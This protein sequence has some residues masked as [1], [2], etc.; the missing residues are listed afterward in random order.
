M[1]RRSHV[2]QAAASRVKGNVHV[3]LHKGKHAKVSS[4][5][6][7]GVC[8]RSG[9][10]AATL[11]PGSQNCREVVPD[12]STLYLCREGGDEGLVGLGRIMRFQ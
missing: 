8:D 10:G 6:R 3:A 7:Y 4:D 1:S 9:L 11:C 5:A 2:R 12:P